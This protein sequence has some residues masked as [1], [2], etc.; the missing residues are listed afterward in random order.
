MIDGIEF[1]GYVATTV[2]LLFFLNG[3]REIQRLSSAEEVQLL[4]YIM[5]F[6]QSLCWLLYGTLLS[7]TSIII[8][9]LVGFLLGAYYLSS[10]SRRFSHL[11]PQLNSYIAGTV[12]VGFLMLMWAYFLPAGLEISR[13]SLGRCATVLSLA[14]FGSPLTALRQV[15]ASKNTS[16]MVVSHVLLSTLVTSLWT[17]YGVGK[18]DSNVIIPNAVGLGLCLIQIAL[19][20][21]YGLPK[22][23]TTGLPLTSQ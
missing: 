12:F 7:N 22:Q 19:F 3:Y 4:P 5:I 18:E 8:T 16:G 17:V 13:M 21:I 14:L 15:I 9:N 11:L 6:L 10:L 23:K 20:A 2:T 1:I